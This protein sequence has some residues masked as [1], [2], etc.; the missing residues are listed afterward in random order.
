MAMRAQITPGQAHTCA[1]PASGEATDHD[2]GSP[3]D[4]LV[5]V[6]FPRS[7]WDAVGALARDLGVDPAEAM[8][9]ALKLLRARVDEESER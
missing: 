9:A 7:A 8:G 4:E 5:I 3:E 1:R 2:T 6:L